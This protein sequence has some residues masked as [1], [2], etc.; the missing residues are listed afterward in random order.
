MFAH[1]GLNFILLK[2]MWAMA[3]KPIQSLKDRL[4][5]LFPFPSPKMLPLVRRRLFSSWSFRRV[6]RQIALH[7]RLSKFR[8]RLRSKLVQ[9]AARHPQCLRSSIPKYFLRFILELPHLQTSNLISLV[10]IFLSI[11]M[12]AAFSSS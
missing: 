12:E 5:S 2:P 8:W 1:S 3:F 11:Q 6:Q 4:S 7:H 9:R 10:G